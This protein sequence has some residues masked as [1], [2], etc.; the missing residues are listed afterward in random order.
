MYAATYVERDTVATVTWAFS[1]VTDNILHMQV[2]LD[3]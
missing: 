3:Y 1:D 2:S